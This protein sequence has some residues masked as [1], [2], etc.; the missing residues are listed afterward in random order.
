MIFGLKNDPKHHSIDDTSFN[1]QFIGANQ[2]KLIYVGEKITSDEFI[3]LSFSKI[4]TPHY[5]WNNPNET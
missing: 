2:W 5:Q 4:E 1:H 3:K